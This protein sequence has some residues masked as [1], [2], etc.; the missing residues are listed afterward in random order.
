MRSAPKTKFKNK[1]TGLGGMT[2]GV[3]GSV[4]EEIPSSNPTTHSP[5]KRKTGK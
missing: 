1:T 2:L 4:K 3:E 5:Q